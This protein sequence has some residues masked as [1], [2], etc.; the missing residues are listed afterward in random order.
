VG[1]LTV[2]GRSPE[3]FFAGGRAMQRLWLTAS[4]LGLAVQP[5]TAITYLFPRLE[6]E[7]G[8]GLGAREVAQL[9]RLRS[10]YLDLLQVQPDEAEVLLFRLARAPAPSA[11]SLRRH[12]DD[13]LILE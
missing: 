5:M 6:L 2:D 13:V 1:L 8:P 9:T 3:S 11:R 7:H 12:L 4:S 10:R